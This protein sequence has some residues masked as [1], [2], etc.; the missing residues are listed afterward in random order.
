M[1]YLHIQI[2]QAF[3]LAH[4]LVRIGVVELM[5]RIL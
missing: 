2:T 5:L 1:S 4:E 3:D